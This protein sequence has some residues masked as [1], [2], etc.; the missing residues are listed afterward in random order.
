MANREQRS[1][2]EKKKPKS[3]KD[4]TKPMATSASPFAEPRN[5]KPAQPGKK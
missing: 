3:D 4:K 5:Q 1:N 2:K